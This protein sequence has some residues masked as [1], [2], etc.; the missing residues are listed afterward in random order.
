MASAE[1]TTVTREVVKTFTV[2]V[3]ED[4]V[5]LNLTMEE[6]N[7]LSFILNRVGGDP[8]GTRGVASNV[9]KALSE[10]TGWVADSRYPTDPTRRAIY[11]RDGNES[12]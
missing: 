5:V 3:E 12:D 10:I 1:K 8:N 11:F 4:T 2:T 6:A 7:V 9:W